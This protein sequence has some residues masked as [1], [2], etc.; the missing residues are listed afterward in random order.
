[1]DLVKAK[2]LDGPNTLGNDR[3][4]SL[5][6]LLCALRARVQHGRNSRGRS[7]HTGGEAHAAVPRS[8]CRK[9]YISHPCRVRSR[10]WPR[11]RTNFMKGTQSNPG[12][13]LGKSFQT[14]IAWIVGAV[15]SS[16]QLFSSC[17]HATPPVMRRPAER[18]VPVDVFMEELLPPAMYSI[19]EKSFPTHYCDG[20]KKEFVPTFKDYGIWFNHVIKVEK[21]KA[22]SLPTT[23]GNI[24]RVGR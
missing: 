3:S 6:C 8:D 13:P 18:W 17:E 24:S 2:L 9:G 22:C 19:F 4:G 21:R 10:S 14:S 5:A 12:A 7:P 16:L 15:G 23:S 20:E 1:M 11:P